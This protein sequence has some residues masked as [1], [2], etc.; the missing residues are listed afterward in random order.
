[1]RKIVFAVAVVTASVILGAGTAYADVPAP[2]SD[3][4]YLVGT[5]IAPG[6]YHTAGPD[7]SSVVPMCY[8]ARTKDTSG[9][10]GSIIANHIS[11][12]PDTV[13]VRA[14]DNAIEFNGGCSWTRIR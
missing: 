4:T 5:D 8:W 13:T 12:G 9:G 7:G 6:T 3:G 1:M 11:H 14:S 2:V 10:L